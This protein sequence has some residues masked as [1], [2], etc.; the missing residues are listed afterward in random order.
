MFS[1]IVT[2]ISVRVVRGIRGIRVVISVK[3]FIVLRALC[4]GLNLAWNLVGA[5]GLCQ[6]LF[7]TQANCPRTMSFSYDDEAYVSS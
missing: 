7:L 1:V 2:V 6:K 3:Q 4:S 5:V